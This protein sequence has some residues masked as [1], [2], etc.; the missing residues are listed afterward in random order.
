MENAR[1]SCSPSCYVER[2][3]QDQGKGWINRAFTTSLKSAA[4]PTPIH[5]CTIHPYTHV[6]AIH[7]YTIHP[8]THVPYTHIPMYHIPMY[9][10][11]IY[12]CTI[13][14]YTHIPYT[15]IP[16]C[17]T[18]IYPYTVHTY[19]YHTYCMQ[20]YKVVYYVLNMVLSIK[21]Y[22]QGQCAV[23]TSLRTPC[24]TG[25]CVNNFQR[26]GSW[27]LCSTLWQQLP[28]SVC[29]YASYFDAYTVLG[30]CIG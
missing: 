17:S 21:P 12:P 28:V 4:Y 29:M 14:P 1:A 8:Y 3:Q 5:P 30:I 22:I 6:P 16:I 20:G 15:N 27:A 9:H 10:I 7:P 19:A 2:N 13:H 26:V 24:T 11:P 18:H 23:K 25:K